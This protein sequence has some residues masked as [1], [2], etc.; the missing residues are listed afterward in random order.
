MLLRVGNTSP[1]FGGSS[2]GLLRHPSV[3]QN[4]ISAEIMLSN[5]IKNL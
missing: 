2:F 4:F 5:I 1:I 3:L